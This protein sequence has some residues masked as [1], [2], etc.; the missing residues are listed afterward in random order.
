MR[1]ADKYRKNIDALMDAPI[2]FRTNRG[3]LR[4]VPIS[5][6][7]DL[8]YGTTYGSIKRKNLKKIIVIR[9]SSIG[10]YSAG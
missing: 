3:T 9:E 4:Q 10:Q 5:A 1:Y 6:V 2:T 7:A 8:Q